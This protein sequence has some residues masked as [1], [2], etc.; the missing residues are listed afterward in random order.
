[1]NEKNPRG[2]SVPSQRPRSPRVPVE[3]ALT[4]EGKTQNGEPFNVRAQAIKISRGGATIVLDAD[5]AVGSIVKLTPPFG[6]ELDA[7]VNGV[8]T[9]QIDG[10]RR[11]GVKLLDDDGWF[12]E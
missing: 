5:V 4:V 1:M 6:R 10:R 8:W 3:F 12:A 2:A 7:E 9:D 11:I